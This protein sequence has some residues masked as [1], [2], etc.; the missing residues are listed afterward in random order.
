MFIDAP[1]RLQPALGWF[2]H[3]LAHRLDCLCAFRWRTDLAPDAG[4]HGAGA[5]L[6]HT[7]SNRPIA[8]NSHAEI[9]VLVIRADDS[10]PTSTANAAWS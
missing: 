4:G 1:I 6:P 8:V 3:R 9:E 7:L 2:G 5:D 10:M